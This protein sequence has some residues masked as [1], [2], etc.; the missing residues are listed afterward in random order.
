MYFYHVKAATIYEI[1]VHSQSLHEIICRKIK[2]CALK[3]TTNSEVI[4]ERK[5]TFRVGKV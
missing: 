1:K 2:I 4:F 5:C 3:W